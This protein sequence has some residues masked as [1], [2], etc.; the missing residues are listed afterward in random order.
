VIE[1]NLLPGKKKKRAAKGG[2]DGGGLGGVLSKLSIPDIGSLLADSYTIAAVVVGVGVLGTLGWWYVGL[3]SRQATVQV[4]LADALRD[5][6]NYAD[7]IQR[8]A[9]IEARRDSIAQK[10][11]IIQDID[12]LRYVWPH[13][14][15]ELA[16][17][18]PDYTWLTQVIQVSV[19]PDVEFQVRGRAGNNLAL[20]TFWRQLQES[21]FIRN[22][23]LVQTEQVSEASGQLVY[24]FQLDCVYGAPPMDFIETVPLFEDPTT[25]NE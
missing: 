6:A 24:A 18:L 7:L 19:G 21:P 5:S 9:T 14:L 12:A 11:E 16:R 13:L 1:V 4:E 3:S 25:V 17:A 20:T 2:G 10:V 23:Q 22:V 15:D 8:N